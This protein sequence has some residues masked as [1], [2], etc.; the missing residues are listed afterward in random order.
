MDRFVFGHCYNLFYPTLSQF[1]VKVDFARDN[2]EASP[3]YL[4]QINSKT[5]SYVSKLY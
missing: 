3:F 5:Y 1:H 4:M 2:H